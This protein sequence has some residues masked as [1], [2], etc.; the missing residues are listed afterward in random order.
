MMFW[1]STGACFLAS[2]LRPASARFSHAWRRLSEQRRE[3]QKIR[4]E[5]VEACLKSGVPPPTTSIPGPI[6]R[7]RKEGS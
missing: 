5:L 4:Y 6:P 2:L 7:M 1:P 3:W